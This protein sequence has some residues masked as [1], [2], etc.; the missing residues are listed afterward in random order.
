MSSPTTPT[1]S[2][3]RD[4]LNEN[5][6]GQMDDLGLQFFAKLCGANRGAFVL[7][8]PDG[9]T[10]GCLAFPK[11]FSTNAGISNAI[12]DSANLTQT[13]AKGDI[14]ASAIVEIVDQYVSAVYGSSSGLDVDPY[15]CDVNGLATLSNCESA[16]DTAK[17]LRPDGDIVKAVTLAGAFVPHTWA[18]NGKVLSMDEVKDF[19]PSKDFR[20]M[21]DLG[22]NTV[23][24]PVPCDTFYKNGE[25]ANTV[26][27]LLY[28]ADKAGLSAILVLVA[29]DTEEEGITDEMVDEH[30]K[31]AAAFAS[32]SST[33]IALQLP[34]QR[35]SLLSAVRSEDEKLP[36]LVPTKVGQLNNLSFPPDSYLFAALDV[37]STTS[38]AGVASSDSEGD[39][40]KMFYH[41]SITCIDRS[42]I[43]WLQ[44]YRDMPVYVTGGFDLAIDNCIDQD[45]KG[46]KDYGQCDRFDETIDS[47]WWQRHR[48]SLAS[49]QLFAYSKG[50]GW[51]FSAWKLY[52]E[53][54][55]GVKIGVLND[56]AKLLCLRDVA[57]AGL[58]PPLSSTSNSSAVGAACL[59]GPLTDFAMGDDT[60]APTPAPHDCG[61]GWWNPATLEC[62]YWIPPPP[63]PTPTDYPTLLKG[64]ACGVVVALVL[65][66]VVKKM[67]GGNEGYQTLP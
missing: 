43:E 39:R 14:T 59:N 20:Q 6:V 8:P 5:T 44:C 23:Q 22:V 16:T 9:K 54:T 31:S 45:E 41:E 51:T 1:C 53:G 50:L 37:T 58:L 52:G 15:G 13:F 36:V 60:F 11:S 56:P 66:W 29:P 21:A 30:V 48:L 18:T 38:V 67:T 64:A 4:V 49:R 2:I 61:E 34:S 35:A 46:F 19:Y 7:N 42:P 55:D 27:Y 62:D 17:S 3:D 24:I 47:G 28:K 25:V 32:D 40:M 26:S 57:A 33:V 65:T 63:A 12:P 10:Y